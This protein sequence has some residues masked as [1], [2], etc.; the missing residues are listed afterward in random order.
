MYKPLL[1]ILM[2]LL[3]NLMANHRRKIQG[4]PK[5]SNIVTHLTGS[6]IRSK[7]QALIP[8][9]RTGKR[10]LNHRQ[11]IPVHHSMGKYKR[12]SALIPYPRTGKRAF[13]PRVG[14]RTP[15]PYLFA[16]RNGNSKRVFAPRTGK[17]AFAPR[18]GKRAFHP[19]TGKR[20]LF[21]SHPGVGEQPTNE[22]PN[23]PLTYASR[24]SIDDSSESDESP[25]KRY[26]NGDNDMSTY[27]ES[28]DL[29]D[30]QIK[31]SGNEDNFADI[32]NN[33]GF[34]MGV[35]DL[36][37]EDVGMSLG[38]VIVLYIQSSKLHAFVKNIQFHPTLQNFTAL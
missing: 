18:T 24:Y 37:P 8:F 35:H 4:N 32:R 22:M 6:N 36:D 7:R 5:L 16:N 29:E 30:E 2:F 13:R 27:S 38:N 17:R 31:R 10:A 19:R 14:K 11:Y 15:L 26:Y 9:P 33:L 12:E 23:M 34:D 25:S 3:H 20:S 28:T 1:C 21:Y